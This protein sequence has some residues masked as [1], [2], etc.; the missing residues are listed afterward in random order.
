LLLTSISHSGMVWNL[1][2]GQQMQL[3]GRAAD[4]HRMITRDNRV[5]LRDAVA[6]FCTVSKICMLDGVGRLNLAAQRQ[7]SPLNEAPT[8]H[9]QALFMDDSRRSRL[10]QATKE[11]FGSYVLIDPT[12][13]GHFKFCLADELP[14]HPDLERSLTNE[15]LEYFSKAI[16]M[17]MASDGVK[18]YSG[19]IAAVLSADFRVFLIDEPEAFLH[20]P[21]ARKLG[22]FLTRIAGERS[23][24]V[25]ASTH[26]SDFLAGCVQ[27]GTS[28]CVIRLTYERNIATAR[29]L[30]ADRLTELM[31]DPLLRSAGVLSSLFYRGAVVC[32]SDTDRA[33]YGEINDRLQRFSKG[34]ADDAIFLNAQNWQTCSNI[35]KPLR[36]MGIPAAAAVDLDVLLSDDLSKLLKAAF[37]PPITASGWTQTRARIKAAFQK[38]LKPGDG[39]P[40]L[41]R[42]VK[43]VGVQGL[44]GMDRDSIEQFLNDLSMYGL[45]L[46]PVG[47]VERWLPELQIVGHA[48]RWLIP[49]FEKMGSDPRDPSYVHPGQE[50][51][52]AF[53]RKIAAWIADPHRKGIPS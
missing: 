38:Q 13:P 33:F 40:E 42:L 45:F 49:V 16:S 14:R 2:T 32:E 7:A 6:A 27:S 9:L 20:P 17:E 23:A 11:A 25:L 30:P 12:T 10:Q 8:S 19:I 46:V 4:L 15:A 37:V 51:V 36:E 53:M 41:S 50:D 5:D 47:E 18:A 35:I 28:V 21:L 39:S 48:S 52:W 24:T 1:V 34:G 29:V 44:T 43:M 22:L 31:R 3:P 26:S